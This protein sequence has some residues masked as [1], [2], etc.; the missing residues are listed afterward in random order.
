MPK[1]HEHPQ[2]PAEVYYPKPMMGGKPPDQMSTVDDGDLGDVMRAILKLANDLHDEFFAVPSLV[3]DQGKV[4]AKKL[5]A[6]TRL[7]FV[8]CGNALDY[9]KRLISERGHHERIRKLRTELAE[10]MRAV[11]MTGDP[12]DG[13]SPLG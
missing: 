5:D 9:A 6:A 12:M 1:Q 8:S 3:D 2:A 7:A 11:G 4:D 10:E 13:E